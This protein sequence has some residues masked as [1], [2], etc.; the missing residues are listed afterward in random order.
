MNDQLKFIAMGAGIGMVLGHVIFREPGF[1]LVMGAATGLLLV[2]VRR[3]E[4]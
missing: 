3:G 4:S 2:S 1:G